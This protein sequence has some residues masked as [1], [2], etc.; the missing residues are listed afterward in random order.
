MAFLQNIDQIDVEELTDEYLEKVFRKLSKDKGPKGWLGYPSGFD[1]IIRFLE[2]RNSEP[3]NCNI[4]SII[5]MAEPLPDHTREKMAYYFKCPV[6]SRYSNIENG[7]IAQQMPGETSFAINWASYI[8]EILDLNDDVPAGTGETGRIVITDLY[9]RATPMVR[10]DTGDIGVAQQSELG[11][12][13]FSRIE[14]RKT[15]ILT[16]TSGEQINAFVFYNSLGDYPELNQVQVVQKGAHYTFR[17]NAGGTEF[18]REKEFLNYY[19]PFLGPG[20]KVS[21]D[22]VKE[23]PNLKSGKRKMIVNLTG[24]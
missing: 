14:G 1:K 3:L 5:G 9:N 17:I 20:A 19:V 16:N 11:I 8:V 24:N 4:R 2:K 10:Y 22:Y 21:I 13:F 6:V 18:K 23:I 7:I 12:P 15:D